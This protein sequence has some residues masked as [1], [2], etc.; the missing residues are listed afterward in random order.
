MAAKRD[1]YEVLGVGRDASEDDVRKAFRRL[2]RQYHPDVNRE[3]GAEAQFKEVNE[4]YEVLSDREQRQLYDR[5]G[6][7]APQGFGGS[8]T[9]FGIE[10]IFETFFGATTRGGGRR[11]ARGADLRYDLEI[12]FDAAVFGTTEELEIPRTVACTRCR[13]DGS[14]PGSQP[15]RCPTCNGAG[16][17]R[18]AQQSVFGQFVNVM[19][20]DRCRGAG[21]IIS[22][23]CKECRGRGEMQATRRL[24]VT[25]PAGIDEGQQ[26]QLRGEGESGARGGPPGD[27]YV[28]IAI[29]PHEQFKRNGND[30]L[31]D[32]TVNV[33]QAAL[34]DEVEVPTVDGSA[35]VKVPAGT[36][37]GRV[38]R[39]RE[40]G[41]PHLRGQSRGDQQVRVRVAVPQQLSDEQ[42]G[43]FEQLART[44]DTE[45]PSRADGRS[46]KGI[47]GRVK[48]VLGGD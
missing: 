46:G 7:N 23:P 35:R 1:Y 38:I 21:Q 37:T 10:D 9:G 2:A 27:L 3:N 17:I 8:A 30:I 41:V 13:G 26:I 47:F 4:A 33:A 22:S 24:S 16:E 43:L 18:R 39:I 29:K 11:P 5:F 20:C 34:G 36:Q 40:K 28:V 14:E 42:R 19:V 15:Q 25:I 31:Y 48:D 44:F 12:A 32:L 6:H 45:A